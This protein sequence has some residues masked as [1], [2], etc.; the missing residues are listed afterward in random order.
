MDIGKWIER[1]YERDF[2]EPWSALESR[3]RARHPFVFELLDLCNQQIPPKKWW[4]FWK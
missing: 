1:R 4:Q 3:V 2:D